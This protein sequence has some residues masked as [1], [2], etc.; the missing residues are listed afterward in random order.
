[1][2]Y[3]L[4]SMQKALVWLLAEGKK[5]I[6]KNTYYDLIYEKKFATMPLWII[7]FWRDYQF[8]SIKSNVHFCLEIRTSLLSR[9]SIKKAYLLY[10]WIHGHFSNILLSFT[11]D[12][13]SPFRPTVDLKDISNNCWSLRPM[14][15]DS[16]ML[17]KKRQNIYFIKNYLLKKLRIQA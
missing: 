12:N 1:V 14:A 16:Q 5:Q 7:L 15:L 17:Q 4:P 3:F 10:V 2:V 6:N 13:S 8:W 11:E 9:K